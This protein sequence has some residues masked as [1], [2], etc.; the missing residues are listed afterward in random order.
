[1]TGKAKLTEVAV[2]HILAR[3]ESAA[4]YASLYDCSA[5]HVRAIWRGELWKHVYRHVHGREP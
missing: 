2:R 1:M 5:M 4:R 3:T